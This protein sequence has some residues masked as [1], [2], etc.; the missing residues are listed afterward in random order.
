MCDE[1]N[2]QDHSTRRPS[3]RHFLK[4]SSV[5]GVAAAGI[6][7]FGARPA[8]AAAQAARPQDTGR[9]DRR[10][11][12]RDGYVMSMDPAVGDFVHAQTS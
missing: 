9:R 5:A 4:A 10:Y 8:D 3:R 12:I 6:D 2:P 1:G 7:L 11:I